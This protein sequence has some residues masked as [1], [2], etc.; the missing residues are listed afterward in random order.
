VILGSNSIEV[1]P[2][3]SSCKTFSLFSLSPINLRR[4]CAD[5]WDASINKNQR[6]MIYPHVQFNHPSNNMSLADILQ[7]REA[8]HT[9]V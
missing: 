8:F 2:Y 4:S 6:N 1:H 5:Y 3:V 7:R 9:F